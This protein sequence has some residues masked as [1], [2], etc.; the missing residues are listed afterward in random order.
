MSDNQ[1]KP[2]VFRSCLYVPGHHPD[3][4]AR[5]YDSEADAVILDLEDA[6]PAP[7]KSRA[8]DIVAQVTALP[9]PPKPT[10]VRVNPMSSGLC[11]DDVRAVA[12]IRLAGIRMAKVGSPEEVRRVADLLHDLGHSATIHVLIESASALEHAFELATASRA[13]TMLGLGESDLQADLN[14]T[15]EG[16]TMDASRA[17]VIIAS[18][19]AGLPSPCQSVYAEPNDLDGLLVTS[20][21]GR[22]LGFLGRMAIHPMQLPIIHTV[23]TPTMGEIDD[24]LEI[25]AAMDLAAMQNRSIIITERGRMV[26]PPAVAKAKQVLELAY[27]LNL[28]ADF[29]GL[30]ARKTP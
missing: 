24:A 23:Y 5:A 17:R 13:V 4:I 11:E 3:R 7:Q 19:A 10:Y 25:C 20:K 27:A 6:V 18:R 26:G 15:K 14:T 8:R 12:G 28:T 9:A 30:E 1:R 21:H 2:Q 22:R 29:A 16:P